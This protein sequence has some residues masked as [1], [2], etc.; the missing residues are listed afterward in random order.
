MKGYAYTTSRV[1]TL[2]N[3]LPSSDLL[4]ALC[5]ASDLKECIGLLNAADITG[6]SPTEIIADLKKRKAVLFDEL[7]ENKDD[8]AVIF[9]PATFHNLK[10]AVKLLYSGSERT[11]M[12][13]EEALVSGETIMDALGN[14]K[15][16]MLPDYMAKAADDSYIAIMRT[17]DGRLSDMIADK[18]CLDAMAAF[19][20]KTGHK[21]LKEYAWTTIAASDIKTVMRAENTG[22][23]APYLTDCSYFSAASLIKA[24]DEGEA[25]LSEF[26]SSVGFGGLTVSNSDRFFEEKTARMMAKEKYNVFSPAPAINF[27]LEYERAVKIIRYILICKENGI[28]QNSVAERVSAY[29]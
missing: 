16:Y 6:S 15:A 14:K 2:E 28:D 5:D 11:D 18:A 7:I 20:D 12:F 4:R 21:I 10:A 9:Y 3:S 26:L 17:G 19:A 1:R 27:M 13:F 8:I 25:A 29:V 23:C 22:L 24:A